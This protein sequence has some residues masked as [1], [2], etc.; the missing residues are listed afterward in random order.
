VVVLLFCVVC[1]FKAAIEKHFCKLAAFRKQNEVEQIHL[2]VVCLISKWLRGPLP[3]YFTPY[4]DHD[5]EL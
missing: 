5:M 3:L 2:S 1:P 4:H